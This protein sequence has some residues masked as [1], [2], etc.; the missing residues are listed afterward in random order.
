MS[1][2]FSDR[3]KYKKTFWLYKQVRENELA[4]EE[5]RKLANAAGRKLPDVEFI[6]KKPIGG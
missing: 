2:L 4:N 3:R 1:G 6:L 5:M